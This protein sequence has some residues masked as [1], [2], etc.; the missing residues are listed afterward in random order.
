ML[1]KL[2]LSCRWI[3][4]LT[5]ITRVRI[6]VRA[7][8]DHLANTP[9]ITLSPWNTSDIFHHLPSDIRRSSSGKTCACRHTVDLDTS[10]C[11]QLKQTM[12]REK[13][14]R[15]ALTGINWCVLAP[16]LPRKRLWT[17]FWPRRRKTESI[18]CRLV[19]ELSLED[20]VT[21]H[22]LLRLNR[23]CNVKAEYQHERLCAQ[24]ND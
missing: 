2:L 11:P 15:L 7:G 5:I 24:E 8:I 18:Y 12:D 16:N 21:L 22:S 10:I 20:P 1:A 23:D 17:R 4:R 9:F 6:P 14:Y 3:Y 19:R 13:R